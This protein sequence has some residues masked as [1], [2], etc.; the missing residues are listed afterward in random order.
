MRPWAHKRWLSNINMTQKKRGKLHGHPLKFSPISYTPP[1]PLTQFNVSMWPFRPSPLTKCSHVTFTW[2]SSFWNNKTALAVVGSWLMV[3]KN[4]FHMPH[5]TQVWALQ[6]HPFYFCRCYSYTLYTIKMLNIHPLIIKTIEY[7][8]IA[9][10]N[11][12]V[13]VRHLPIR[14]SP[15]RYF[16]I[17]II[18]Q[19]IKKF[20]KTL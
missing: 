9:I 15:V 7:W 12:R 16:F 1:L 11:S 3:P 19:C 6:E 20:E 13:P 10:C 14:H 4:A 18:S 17:K 2:S 8:Y 5:V